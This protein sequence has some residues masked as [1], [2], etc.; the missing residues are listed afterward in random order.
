MREIAVKLVPFL[1]DPKS[2]AASI[3]RL[4]I[5]DRSS[6]VQTAALR[7]LAQIDRERLVP[8]LIEVFTDANASAS[9]RDVIDVASE[10]M[11][12]YLGEDEIA[13]VNQGV[14]A[15]EEQR[16]AALDRFSGEVE[17]WRHDL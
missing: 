4:A 6:A 13:A 17:W 15:K 9:S 1:K 14:R 3:R 16:D 11:E 7:V 10:L 12:K 8:V 2:L 5:E